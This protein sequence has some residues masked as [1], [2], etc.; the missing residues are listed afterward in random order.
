MAG[1]GLTEMV[2]HAGY[3]KL[4]ESVEYALSLVRAVAGERPSY[5]GWSAHHVLYL[6]QRAGCVPAEYR[7]PDFAWV[8]KDWPTSRSLLE[9]YM[10]MPIGRTMGEPVA[11]SSPLTPEQTVL[12]APLLPLL[13]ANP[14]MPEHAW[15][16]ALAR[17]SY[18]AATGIAPDDAVHAT[19]FARHA[20]V[21][22]VDPDA[23]ERM[24]EAASRALAER[25]LL[26]ADMYLAVAKTERSSIEVAIREGGRR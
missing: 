8:D 11:R 2:D 20:E 9:D 22:P 16:T 25:G 24:L 13:V 14:G 18:C 17:L 19:D 21:A 6:A 10:R 5:A 3:A 1:G 15:V 4:S 7:R 12:I 23:Y 26:G